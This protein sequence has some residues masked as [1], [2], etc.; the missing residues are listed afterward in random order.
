[1]AARGI[2]YGGRSLGDGAWELSMTEKTMMHKHLE[3]LERLGTVREANGQY[4][5]L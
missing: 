4:H 1:V 2:I 5:L 3:R